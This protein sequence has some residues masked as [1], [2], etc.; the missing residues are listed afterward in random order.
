MIGVMKPIV[1]F[2][3]N[4]MLTKNKKEKI[5]MN[6]NRN[7]IVDFRI[8]GEHDHYINKDKHIQPHQ[9]KK[10]ATKPNKKKK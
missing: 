5:Y 9:K 8:N 3:K 4:L 7:L 2:G 6:A 10:F 1:R